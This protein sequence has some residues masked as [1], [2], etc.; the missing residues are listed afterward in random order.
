[1]GLCGVGWRTDVEGT[2]LFMNESQK[3]GFETSKKTDLVFILSQ[4]TGLKGR[5][6]LAVTFFSKYIWISRRRAAVG[7]G[8]TRLDSTRLNSLETRIY[9]KRFRKR[10]TDRFVF[11]LASI[12]SYYSTTTTRLLLLLSVLLWVVIVLM[13]MLLWPWEVST[14][15][16]DMYL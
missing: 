13:T 6:K 10:T 14:V 15:H 12:F 9:S 3:W 5:K 2:V 11:S 4:Y 1:V 16:N 7:S 8:D